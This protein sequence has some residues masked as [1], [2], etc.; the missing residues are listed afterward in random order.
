MCGQARGQGQCVSGR[1]ASLGYLGRSGVLARDGPLRHLA[2]HLRADEGSGVYPERHAEGE[3]LVDPHLPFPVEDAPEPLA[4]DADAP[5]ELGD[6]DTALSAHEIN[7]FSGIH[8]SR[9]SVTCALSAGL[10]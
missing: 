6:A 5:G 1:A 2:N 8:S 3:E 4:V 7:L 9:S 10:S